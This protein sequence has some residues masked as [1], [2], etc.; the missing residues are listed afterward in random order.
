MTQQNIP[1]EQNEQ[2]QKPIYLW[3]LMGLL[4]LALLGG[5]GYLYYKYANKPNDNANKANV[6]GA[7]VAEKHLLTA[8]DKEQYG[9]Q[10]NLNGEIT[11]T[12]VNG[13]LIPSIVIDPNSRPLDTDGDR[14]SD[15]EEATQKTDPNN[16]DT[17][18]DL[19]YDGDEVL[20]WKTDPA[21]ADT[22][23]DGFDDGAEVKGGYNPLGTG[24]LNTAQ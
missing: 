16:P 18:G 13:T 5:G 8:E 21:K 1:S 10:A 3:F 12:N 6:N 17:D 15:E 11:Y 14:L 22:D 20:V 2:K 19:I 7:V 9:I 24:L 23:E 4:V